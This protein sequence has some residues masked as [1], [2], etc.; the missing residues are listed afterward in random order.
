MK[1]TIITIGS[2]L[3][4][5]SL[6]AQWSKVDDFEGY[7]DGQ[8]LDPDH[9]NVATGDWNFYRSPDDQYATIPTWNAVAD[10]GDGSQGLVLEVD[11][12]VP[13]A[14]GQGNTTI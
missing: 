6:F 5:G 11:P 9:S 8:E 4:S 14:E 3:L 7:T 2:I 10:P 12:G 1:K 13:A